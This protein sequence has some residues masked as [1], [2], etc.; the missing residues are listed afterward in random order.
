MVFGDT[1]QPVS[2]NLKALSFTN[3]RC[4]SGKASLEPLNDIRIALIDV[5]VIPIDLV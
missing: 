5:P 4:S 3:G 2:N 1:P